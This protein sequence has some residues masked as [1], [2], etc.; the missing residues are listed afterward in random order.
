MAAPFGR[1]RLRDGAEQPRGAAGC[2]LGLEMT[3]S[4]KNHGDISWAMGL[5][6]GFLWGFFCGE[7]HMGYF[8]LGGGFL[9]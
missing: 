9:K 4:W 8:F 5:I 7:N 1:A 3:G 2:R 6:M